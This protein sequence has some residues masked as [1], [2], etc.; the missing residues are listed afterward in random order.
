MRTRISVVAFPLLLTSLAACARTTVKP[1]IGSVPFAGV[2]SYDAVPPESVVVYRTAAE[3][4]S[5]FEHLAI[6]SARGDFVL[7]GEEELVQ[8]LRREAGRL[9]ANGL[10][11]AGV[12]SPRGV[13]TVTGAIIGGEDALRRGE[14]VAIRVR[15]DSATQRR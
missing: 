6:V 12:V 15:P 2:S 5:P 13:R 9:G 11:V 3:I 8:S 1:F 4:L 14:G 7:L 10:L